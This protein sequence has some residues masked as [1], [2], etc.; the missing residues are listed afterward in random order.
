MKMHRSLTEDFTNAVVHVLALFSDYLHKRAGNV[1]IVVSN[2]HDFEF[3]FT[4][5]HNVHYIFTYQNKE[6]VNNTVHE[7][8]L[9][10]NELIFP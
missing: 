8:N 7:T 5:T 2:L 1:Y 10:Q 6:V 9:A 3:K 4:N